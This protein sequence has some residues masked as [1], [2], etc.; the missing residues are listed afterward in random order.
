MNTIP[1]FFSPKMV[2]ESG[3]ESPSAAKPPKVVESWR[4]FPITIHEP[5][6]VTLDE[7]ARAHDRA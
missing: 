5:A 4:K 2:A 6:P 7:Y 1:V 3:C